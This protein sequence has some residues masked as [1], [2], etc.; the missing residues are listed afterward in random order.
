VVKSELQEYIRE[1][2]DSLEMEVARLRGKPAPCQSGAVFVWPPT[3]GAW[4]A[5]LNEHQDHFRAT[6]RVCRDGLRRQHNERLEAREFPLGDQSL[7]RQSGHMSSKGVRSLVANGF[8]T[9]CDATLRERFAFF[10]VRVAHQQWAVA[11]KEIP[12]RGLWLALEPHL[13]EQLLPLWDMIPVSL[14]CG[15]GSRVFKVTMRC[16]EISTD[17][18]N[19]IMLM[20]C[21]TR[22]VTKAPVKRKAKAKADA[23]DSEVDSE[24]DSD[25]KSLLGSSG[26]DGA[27][28]LCSSGDSDVM[29]PVAHDSD[30]GSVGVD[31]PLGAGALPTSDADTE[32]KLITG[33]R[34]APGTHVQWSNEY[35][36]LV[37]NAGFADVKM[38]VKP[39]WCTEDMLGSVLKSKT[40]LVEGFDTTA[41]APTQTVFALRAWMLWK[42]QSSSPFMHKRS[43]RDVWTRESA[44]L[45]ADIASVALAQRTQDFIG[46]W[47]PHVMRAA[48]DADD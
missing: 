8:H 32:D 19:G 34:M 48:T 47:A 21:D 16:V 38:L 30:E 31:A 5:W 42:M 2:K 22:E 45:R 20:P 25:W 17:G 3:K 18:L 46:R 7:V 39:R 10:A 6:V 40:L 36:T 41:S 43:R 24:E 13:S 12:S 9:V 29:D 15:A 33:P 27:E 4:M 11:L 14:L 35:F 26:N 44:Q 23:A 1:N 37:N 28:S